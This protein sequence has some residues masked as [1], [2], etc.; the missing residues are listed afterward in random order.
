V[1]V[2]YMRTTRAVL[3]VPL[4]LLASSGALIPIAAAYGGWPTAS[5]RGSYTA[6]VQLIDESP[7]LCEFVFRVRAFKGAIRGSLEVSMTND[8][9]ALTLHATTFT[10]LQ[11]DPTH[12]TIVGT[13]DLIFNGASMPITFAVEIEDNGVDEY[14]GLSFGPSV[15]SSIVVPGESTDYDGRIT[16]KC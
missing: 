2:R 11:L 7:L 1:E 9:V 13:G 5:G 16:I 3:L 10:D 12:A 8:A 14:F 4:L 15:A 6:R